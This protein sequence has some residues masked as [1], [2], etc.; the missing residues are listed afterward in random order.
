M[1]RRLKYRPRTKVTQRPG[2]R[3]RSGKMP[4]SEPVDADEMRRRVLFGQFNKG[5]W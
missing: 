5:S 2:T 4:V 1:S 3:M